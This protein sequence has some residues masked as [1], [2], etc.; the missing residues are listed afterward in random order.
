MKK[1]L[2]L[3][4]CFAGLLEAMHPYSTTAMRS[5]LRRRTPQAQQ[6]LPA[7]AVAPIVPR[8]FFQY[9]HNYYQ[10]PIMKTLA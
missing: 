3:M 8:L 2:L 1:L 4:L 9:L 10:F 7:A 5:T 6:G